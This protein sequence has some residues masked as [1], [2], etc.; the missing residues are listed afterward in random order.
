MAPAPGE[1]AQHALTATEQAVLDAIDLDRIIDLAARLINAGGE[2]PGGTEAASVAVLEAAAGELGL[3]TSIQPA[4]PDR[5]NIL[6][7]LPPHPAG[8]AAKSS[9]GS[10][11]APAGAGTPSP[12]S[13]VPAAPGLMFLGHSDVVPAGPGWTRQPFHAAVD[14]GR[15]YG[16]GATDM[17]GGLAAVL[18]AMAALKHSG[19]A[20]TGPVTLVCTVDEEDLGLGIRALAASA[21][22]HDYLG[23]IVAEP[24][25]LET[26]V[27]C[28]GD[29][30]L[31]LEVTGRPAHSGRP[32]DGR[33]AISAAARIC[34]LV[35]ADH[36][37]LQQ[38]QDELLGAGSWN[39]G[40]IEGGQGTSVVAPSCSLSLD[41]RLM[42]DD[43]PERILADLLAGVS[44]AGIDTDGISVSGRVSMQM[45]GFRT[46]AD[47]PLVA[48]AVASVESAG[49]RTRIGGWTAA[50]DGGFVVRDFGIPAIVL[51]PGGLNDQA[52]QADESVSLDELS[53]A[54]RTYA[55]LC[56]RTLS[57]NTIG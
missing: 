35:R 34:E 53:I 9:A 1:A 25:D 13:P 16:R 7:T 21:L 39:V 17:K 33:N 57:P 55:L 8:T 19:A 42:P 20:L 37:R 52:H 12:A 36:E 56:L 11:S 26:V 4:A 28:R 32:A 6:I 51:G 38:D 14:G 24:T 49:G 23:C 29:S 46:P 27:G 10:A 45:P 48:A 30:Y 43:D 41:R 50:C 3:E 15:L 22:P 31:E 47:H 18:G 5:P 40:L 54:A 2:N 44:A